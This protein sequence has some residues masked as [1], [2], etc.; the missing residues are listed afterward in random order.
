MLWKVSALILLAARSADAFCGGVVCRPQRSSSGS[1]RRAALDGVSMKWGVDIAPWKLE[2]GL[3][4]PEFRLPAGAKESGKPQPFTITDEQREALEEDGAV[5]IPGLLDKEWLEYLRGVTDWQVKNPHVWS[6]AGVASG[7]YDYI[8]RSV[9]A[10]NEGFAEFMYYSP[11][12]SALAGLKNAK[13]LRLS[14]DLLMVNPN[15]GFKWHQDN[16]NGPI[17]A[18]GDDK[19]LRWWVTMDDSP[20]DHGAPV[21]LKGS[22]RNTQVSQ[23]AVFVDLEKDGLLEYPEM[24]EFRPKA[25]DLIVWHAR[26]IHKIDGPKDQDWGNGRRRVLG[27][28]VALN[29][30][31]YES[32]GRALFSDMGSHGLADGDPL[33]H[34]LFPRI[35]PEPDPHEMRERAAGRCTRSTEGMSRLAGNMFASMGEMLSWTNVVNPDAE[36]EKAAAGKK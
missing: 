22:H 10:S 23:D 5:V 19:A 33:V 8:Q 28:T 17:D 35:Y 9:W 29:D 16:Q 25:G 20:P 31:T 7:L 30:A 15:K 3:Q 18:F 36:K 24:L 32:M 21:Y 13:E 26:S 12:A 14:T 11:L 6:V 1:G 27:G 34:P 2:Y 4:S